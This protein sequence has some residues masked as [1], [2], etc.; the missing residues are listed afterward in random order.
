MASAKECTLNRTDLL[1]EKL[2]KLAAV[3][4]VCIDK[5]F[6]RCGIDCEV[7]A[8]SA[9]EAATKFAIWANKDCGL[10]ESI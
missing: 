3:P 6:K 4:P 8:S 1:I 7:T 9:F 5:A 10:Q 2:E